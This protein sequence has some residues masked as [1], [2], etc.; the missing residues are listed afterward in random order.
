L[1]HFPVAVLDVSLGAAQLLGMIH[2]FGILILAF[3]VIELYSSRRCG[4]HGLQLFAIR[5]SRYFFIAYD[6]R[7]GPRSSGDD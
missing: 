1:A 4:T 6:K 5:D 3:S 2:S 7:C